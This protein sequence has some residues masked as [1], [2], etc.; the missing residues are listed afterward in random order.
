MTY[1]GWS[2][3]KTKPNHYTTGIPPSYTL[4]ALYQEIKA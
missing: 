1:N 4:C 2:A 3:I